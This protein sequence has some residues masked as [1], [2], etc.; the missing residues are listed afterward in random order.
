MVEFGLKLE[1]NRVSEWADKYIDYNKLKLLIE[2]LSELIK[3]RKE[4]EKRNPNLSKVITEEI[5]L[6]PH[7]A[8]H[9]HTPRTSYTSL[10]PANE[11]SEKV[12]PL[13]AEHQSPAKDEVYLSPHKIHV[14][15]ERRRS[16]SYGTIQEALTNVASYF[17]PHSFE[18]KLRNL[19]QS[20]QLCR[21]QFTEQLEKEIEKV[22]LFYVWKCKEIKEQF[23]VL[24]SSIPETIKRRKPEQSQ[25]FFSTRMLLQSVKNL[26]TTIDNFQRSDDKHLQRMRDEEENHRAKE[27]DSIQRAIIDL[28]RDAK[29]LANFAILNYTGFVK[30]IKKYRKKAEN[31]KRA[32]KDELD[33][34]NKDGKE[35]EDLAYDMELKYA[36]WFCGGNIREAQGQMLPKKGDNLDMDWSQLRLGY[37]L[38]MCAILT[39]WIC[40]DC[41]YG[42]MVDGHSTIGGR[43]GFPVFR[44]CGG[45]LLLHWFWGF[46]TFVWSRFR[47]N[48][49]YLFDFDPR[50]VET[51]LSIIGD[52]VDETL[53]YLIL[54][55][56]YYKAGA[57]DIPQIL[58]TG[59]YPFILILYTVKKLI[60]PLRTRIPLWKSILVVITSPVNSSSFFQTYVGD[61]FTSMVKVFQDLLWIL[62]FVFSGDFLLS[63]EDLGDHPHAWKDAFWYKH[64]A[65]PVICLAPLWFRFNQCL[66]RYYDTNKRFPHLANAF[67]YALSQCVTL[68]GAFHPLY[69]MH[70]RT[71]R[72]IWGTDL[73]QVFWMGLFICSSLYSWCWD[74]YMDW[75][76][77]LPEYA[78]LGPRLM[79]PKKIYYYLVIFADLFLRFMWVMTLL[80]PQSGANFEFPYYLS[81]ISMIVEL[82]RRTIWGFFRL[83]NEHRCNT[84]QFR[85]VDFVPLHFDTGHNHKYKK[86]E[87]K[88]GWS[89]LAEVFAVSVAVI[90]IS[91]SSIIAAKNATANANIV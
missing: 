23:D 22:H 83:E 85:R 52:V 41:V 43:T 55:L 80:P 27:E 16:G 67:K 53:V 51:P 34:M 6:N 25:N 18:D 37:R 84:S 48:Y 10:A 31:T 75:G 74:I 76:L 2:K 42:Y 20:E 33:N 68:F 61:V 30:I 49:I 32:F 89:V 73:F 26:S 70:Y 65:I 3:K 4:L 81:A 13:L 66:R 21:D 58:P 39:I 62:C 57:D 82:F 47:V 11:S 36:R 90:G 38:G 35:A 79:F 45:L 63:E 72:N 28:H 24:K 15:Q 87:E 40:W 50:I 88:P 86:K 78:M 44:G 29:L 1:D 12:A 8:D 56:L 91:I 77:G 64:V 19:H 59:A 71:G 46:S 69:L 5:L 14:L 54:M 9:F 17:K 7:G 60:F